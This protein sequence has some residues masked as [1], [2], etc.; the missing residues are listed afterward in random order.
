MEDAMI[1]NKSAYERGFGH[2]CVYKSFMNEINEQ[3]TGI[4]KP[5]SR[6]R[7]MN[8]KV[9]AEDKKIELEKKGLDCDGLP[10]IGKKLTHGEAEMCVYDTV[11]GKA[12]YTNYKD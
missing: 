12:K 5:K 9:N 10:F 4:A 11:L 6:F 7:M 8:A 3:N 2:G 1:L